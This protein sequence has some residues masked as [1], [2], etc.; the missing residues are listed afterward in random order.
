MPYRRLP[1]TDNARM[2]ALKCA[3]TKGKEIPPFKLAFSQSSY[4]K[5]QSFLPG[6]EKSMIE[7]KYAYQKQI[8]NNKEHLAIQK[9]ARL[10]ISHFIQVMNMAVL[11]NELPVNTREFYQFDTDVKKT[12]TL[13]TETELIEYGEK[14]IKG[15]QNRLSR[16]MA[17]VTNPTIAV[18]KVR[19]E[20][21]IDSHKFQKTL[22]KNQQRAQHKLAEMR[23]Q[24]DSIIQQVWNEVEDSFSDLPEEQKREQAQA[25]G[26]VY[27]YR[28][29]ELKKI[30]LFD[31]EHISL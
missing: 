17:P 9:K 24:A 28:K 18:V 7:Y 20:N 10:Y 31:E 2:K 14:V 13:S 29:N 3:Y 1:N 4:Q 19:F 8:D 12:P 21:F 15:E 16:G 11:R 25:Y 26:V 6:F 5:V 30:D 27:V 23:T 22:Q